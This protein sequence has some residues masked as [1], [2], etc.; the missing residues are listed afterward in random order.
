MSL[1]L[2]ALAR[3]LYPSLSGPFSPVFVCNACLAMVVCSSAAALP[4][5]RREVAA[6]LSLSLE[7]SVAHPFSRLSSVL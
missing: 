1:Y 6:V 4:A 3:P 2:V 7:F 5:Q